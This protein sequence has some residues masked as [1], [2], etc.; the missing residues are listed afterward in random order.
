MPEDR[1]DRLLKWLRDAHAMEREADTML[2]NMGSRLEHYPQL[3]ARIE[4]HVDETRGQLATLERCIDR[5]GGSTSTAKDAIGSM[6]ATVH[7]MGN[8]MMEDEVAKGAGLSYAFEHLEIA[9][10]RALV[11]AA[12]EAGQE[13]I[14]E[15]CETIMA[16]EVAMADWLFA[17][18]PDVIRE[19]LARDA[20]G[21]EAKR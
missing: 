2:R 10:Y 11:L 12:R 3:R 15:A 19:F 14:A 8:A 21:V 13:E 17:N 6:M 9:T 5:L 4:Q 20:E 7:A 18:Q 1:N 16:E